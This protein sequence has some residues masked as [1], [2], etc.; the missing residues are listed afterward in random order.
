MLALGSDVFRAQFFGSLKGEDEIETDWNYRD[1]KFF[2]ST[3]YGVVNLKGKSLQSMCGLFHI[4]D[5][6]NVSEIKTAILKIIKS[7]NYQLSDKEI[8]EAAFFAQARGFLPELS[9][10]LY[11]RILDHC[12]T[13]HSGIEKMF[14]QQR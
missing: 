13:D 4:S 14:N 12:G 8:I 11:D 2:I 10:P 7:S 3:F 5:Y 1:F 6:Y 9:R